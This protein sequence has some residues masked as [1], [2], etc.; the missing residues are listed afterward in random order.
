MAKQA[1]IVKAKSRQLA[2]VPQP[3]VGPLD[4]SQRGYIDNLEKN[5]FGDYSNTY[6]PIKGTGGTDLERS[7]SLIDAGFNERGTGRTGSSDTRQ[8]L[9]SEQKGKPGG[10]ELSEM[11][12]N[13]RLA[14][15]LVTDM[16]HGA[17]KRNIRSEAEFLDRQDELLKEAA[18]PDYETIKKSAIFPNIGSAAAKLYGQKIKTHVSAE[19]RY[20]VNPE[21]KQVS[22][23][24]STPAPTITRESITEEMPGKSEKRV[25][26]KLKK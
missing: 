10:K 1:G 4:Q 14:D 26:L 23:I 8:I 19:N 2:K 12:P 3:M 22:P 25:M 21:T 17:K 16:F 15:R 6:D 20:Y 18:G 13:F 11:S 9:I 7:K 5:L 24:S